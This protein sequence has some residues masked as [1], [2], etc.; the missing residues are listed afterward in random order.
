MGEEGKYAMMVAYTTSTTHMEYAHAQRAR[1]LE[2][3]PNMELV[4]DGAVPTAE[5]EESIDTAYERAKEVIML[6][7]DLKGFTGIASTDGPGIARAVEELGLSGTVKIVACGT[8]NEFRP[9]VMSGTVSNVMLWDPALSGKAMVE[10]ARRILNG[11]SVGAGT[12]LG[13][14]G[15]EDLLLFQTENRTLIGN[16]PISITIDNIGDYDF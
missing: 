14:P 7:P 16:A 4:N 12:N 3:F 8:P 10:I 6:H 1:Q 13:L 11:E 15:Y 5:S 2:A 9:F